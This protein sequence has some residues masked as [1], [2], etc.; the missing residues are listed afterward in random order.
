MLLAI[1]GVA[2]IVYAFID[3]DQFI[4][5]STVPEPMD[6]FFGIVA[7]LLLLEISR[8][9]VGN[10]FTLVV[11]GFLLYMYFGTFPGHHFP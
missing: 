10:T 5:R 7:I 2:A 4:R 9:I 6:L 11:A 3:T 1:L 8:R